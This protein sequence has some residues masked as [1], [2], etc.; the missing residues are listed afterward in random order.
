M[1]EKK[2]DGLL[3]RAFKVLRV[4]SSYPEGIGLSELARLSEVPKA[5][6]F[7]IITVLQDEGVLVHDEGNKRARLSI[8]ALS[9]LGGILTQSGVVGGIREVLDQLS[10]E[11]GETSGFDML[12]DNEIIVL[13]QQ[14][15]PSLIGQTTKQTPRAQPPWLTSTGK[16][17]LA[18]RSSEEV[19]ALLAPSFSSENMRTLE[20]F[21]NSLDAVREHG[22]SWVFGELERDAAAIGAAVQTEGVPKYAVW[23]G[24]P[25]YR[26]TP[27]TAPK[28][29]KLVVAAAQTVSQLLHAADSLQ[30]SNSYQL[31]PFPGQ[32]I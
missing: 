12:H 8:G 24:G 19:T 14:V 21:V 17:I 16:A 18:H 20:L 9:I 11:T 15:G 2:G 32:G 30:G 29:G 10:A 31:S 26:I 27:E 23:I 25:T 13:L 28:L 6:C 7:R 5:T 4:V 1:Y 22:Y 3:N